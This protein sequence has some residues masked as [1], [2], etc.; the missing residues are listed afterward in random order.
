MAARRSSG[1]TVATVEARFRPPEAGRSGEVTRHL[2]QA[3]P[4]SSSSI[5][6]TRPAVGIAD[7]KADT[8]QAA[9][10]QAGEERSPGVA[11]VVA[12]GKLQT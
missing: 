11:L 8:G 2:C 7:H 9:L 6:R 10:D 3:A 1:L 4:S 12:G 5:A